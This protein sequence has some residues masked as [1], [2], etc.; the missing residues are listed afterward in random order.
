MPGYPGYNQ[1]CDDLIE[2]KDGDFRKNGHNKS[3]KRIVFHGIM[4]ECNGSTNC[5]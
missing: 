3:R 1:L 2:D 5:F 4:R